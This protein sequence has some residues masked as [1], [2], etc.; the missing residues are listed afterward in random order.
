MFAEDVGL[1]DDTP[2]T[3]VLKRSA[4]H[5][6][7]SRGYLE[8]LFGAMQKGGEFWGADVR[9]FNGGLFDSD[10][11]LDLTAPE[12]HSLLGAARLNWSKVEPAIFGTLFEHS[13]DSGTRGK[14]GAHYTPVQDILDVTVPVILEP[15]RAEW[16]A[17]KDNVRTLLGGKAKDRLQKATAALQAFHERLADAVLTD[18]QRPHPGLCWGGGAVGRSATAQFSALRGREARLRSSVPTKKASVHT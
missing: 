3:R 11:A 6:E 5:P 13:L 12:A 10:R 1:L 14:R 4:E 2:L 17:V 15:L 7:R 16:D 8:E 9:H 18:P